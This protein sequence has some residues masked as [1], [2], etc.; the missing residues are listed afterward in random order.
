MENNDVNKNIIPFSRAGKSGGPTMWGSV[1]AGGAGGGGGS[2]VGPSGSDD[3]ELRER[4]AGLEGAFRGVASA[5]ESLRQSQN[6]LVTA[7]IG[8]G[9]LLF[10]LQIYSLQRI[11]RMDDKISSLTEKVNEV[12]GKIGTE[13]RDI[14]KTLAESITAAKQAPPQVILMPAPQPAPPSDQQPAAKP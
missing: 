1:D 7:V 13:L 3:M 2:P 11:D 10:A 5:M 12:P 9:A 8:V 14:T 6:V 4:V